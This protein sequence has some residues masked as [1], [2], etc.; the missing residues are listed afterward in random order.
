MGAAVSADGQLLYRA[1]PAAISLHDTRAPLDAGLQLLQA[2]HKRP[3]SCLA[4]NLDDTLLAYGTLYDAKD[5]E[6]QV[7]VAELRAPGQ[8]L[9]L[10]Q[11]NEIH[12]NDVTMVAFDPRSPSILATGS[13]DGLINIVDMRTLG[14]VGAGLGLDGSTVAAP[15]T[16]VR[17]EH[18]SVPTN[19]EDSEFAGPEEAVI[20]TLNASSAVARTRFF[21]AESEYLS[22]TTDDNGL[23]I[24]FSRPRADDTESETIVTFYSA[25]ET[26]SQWGLELNYL[27][28][29]FQPAQSRR[30][31][32]LLG[33]SENH[34]AIVANVDQVGVEEWRERERVRE[35]SR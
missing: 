33:S 6:C 9:L 35:L 8:A 12:N 31:F 17:P 27:V 19:F 23:G 24:F 21:G 4:A 2:P 1:T 13:T 34:H 18:T 26:A 11:L 22:A 20:L 5:E 15:A 16:F 32:A 30:L 25:P 10:P 7:G 14:S 29:A 28:D 3:Y